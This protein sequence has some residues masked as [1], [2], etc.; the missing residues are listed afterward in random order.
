M[1]IECVLQGDSD[2]DSA[3]QAP[4]IILIS[5][6]MEALFT[7]TEG[8]IETIHNYKKPGAKKCIFLRIRR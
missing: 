2:S 5:R 7:K 1:S 8:R 4:R 6:S 3:P